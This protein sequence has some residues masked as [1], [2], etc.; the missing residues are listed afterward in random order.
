MRSGAVLQERHRCN[1]HGAG[2]RAGAHA[3]Q[4]GRAGLA[5]RYYGGA[6]YAA[7]SGTTPQASGS[8]RFSAPITMSKASCSRGASG[9]RLA[10]IF[11]RLALQARCSS[12]KPLPEAAVPP[13]GRARELCDQRG[14]LWWWMMCAEDRGMARRLFW[15]TV[16]VHPDSSSWGKYSTAIRFRLGSAGIG[17]SAQR[18]PHRYS[19]PVRSGSPPSP[20]PP[21]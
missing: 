5:W 19:S 21:R 9:F 8:T 13:T 10:A 20:W 2:D 3:P 1:D 6:V 18:P 14:A 7:P 17:E 12:I 15:S 11:A 4:D 16:G